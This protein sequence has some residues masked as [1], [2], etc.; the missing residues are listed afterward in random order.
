[1]KKFTADEWNKTMEFLEKADEGDYVENGNRMVE[2]TNMAGGRYL[3]YIKEC[4]HDF[5]GN[6]HEA[7][8]VAGQSDSEIKSTHFLNHAGDEPE[9]RK[10]EDYVG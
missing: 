5:M 2:V 9:E 1:M 10:T 6:Y 7:W 8:E 3:H 4:W